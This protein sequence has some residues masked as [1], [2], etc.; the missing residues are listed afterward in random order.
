M[1]SI[2]RDSSSNSTAEPPSAGRFFVSAVIL[3]LAVAACTVWIRP[4]AR[5]DRGASANVQ[6]SQDVSIKPAHLHHRNLQGD[7]SVATPRWWIANFAPTDPPQSP[8]PPSTAPPSLA[9]AVRRSVAGAH[10]RSDGTTHQTSCRRYERS[11]GGADRISRRENAQAGTIT[12]ATTRDSKPVVIT[13]HERTNSRSHKTAIDSGA[14]HD[15][16][17]N[18]CAHHKYAVRSANGLSI[19]HAFCCANGSARHTGA[20]DESSH[21]ER[22]F[23][24]AVR[25]SVRFSLGCPVGRADTIA[26][27]ESS[28]YASPHHGRALP[29]SV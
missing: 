23:R 22:A 17:C 14:R 21:D 25:S 19:G 8:S 16:S 11:H 18:S 3:T 26:R 13:F 12:H 10:R 28:D 20:C 9:D 24:H 27:D 2:R 29:T 1:K 4:T 15:G 7:V 5:S 6:I